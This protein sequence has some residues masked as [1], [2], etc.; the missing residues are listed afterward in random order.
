M[1]NMSKD[2]DESFGKLGLN[3]LSDEFDRQKD[4]RG[5][6]LDDYEK[7]HELN[8]S[9]KTLAESL[10]KTT[11]DMLRGKMVKLQDE[12]NG[13]MDTGVKISAAQ[14]EIIARRVALLQAEANLLDAE[15]AKSNV[16]MTRDNEGNFSYTYTADQD[17]INDAQEEYADKFYD[18]LK[19]ERDYMDQIQSEMLQKRQ[20]FIDKLN[21]LA[22][23][24]KDDQE[25]FEAAAEQ[26]RNDYLQYMD[27]YVGEQDMDMQEMARLRD[28]DWQDF[29]YHT[30]SKLAEQDD[31]ITNFK[32]T[33]YGDL[34]DAYNT[35]EEDAAN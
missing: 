7:Y 6:Y 12:I 29:E 27:Y 16:R 28:D 5:L 32:D 13:K 23:Q 31:F 8:K 17:A 35:A 21:D 26:L 2:Y 3:W 24:Y 33:I 19:Y 18:L 14:A 9:A 4:V 20:E 25:G 1:E 22:D 11:N 30:N 34:A 15:N 10:E